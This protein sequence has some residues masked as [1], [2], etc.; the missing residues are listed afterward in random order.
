[1]PIQLKN[2]A[3]THKRPPLLQLSSPYSKLLSGFVPTE[4]KIKS[5]LLRVTLLF[6]FS[7]SFSLGVVKYAFRFR[8]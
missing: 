2:N 1:M 3:P 4:S 8:V 5:L 6:G 7:L